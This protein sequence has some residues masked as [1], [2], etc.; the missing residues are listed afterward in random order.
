M[1]QH[2]HVRVKDGMNVSVVGELVETY[3]CKCG[4][5]WTK[6]YQVQGREPD[7]LSGA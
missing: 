5:T 3:R 4:S 7:A 1:D 2:I 6:T